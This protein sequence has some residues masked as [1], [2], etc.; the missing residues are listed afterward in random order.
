[1]SAVDSTQVRMA[2]VKDIEQAFSNVRRGGG[3]TLHEARV[4]DDYGSEDEQRKARE[5]D[6]DQHWWEIPKGTLEELYDAFTFLDGEGFRYYLA[7]FMT[8]A[9]LHGQ[10]SEWPVG[11]WTVSDLAR[12]DRQGDFALL[13]EE[14]ARVVA[15]FLRFVADRWDEGWAD[16][17]VAAAAIRKYWHRYL[18]DLA[19]KSAEA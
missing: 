17:K 18:P 1:M 3:T 11:D 2:L 4:Q 9:L 19:G 10:E 6:K 13:S 16:A 14:Q 15:R 5:K 7:A 8:Y 12:P